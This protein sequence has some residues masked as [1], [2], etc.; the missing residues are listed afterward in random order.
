VIGIPNRHPADTF[1]NRQLDGPGH[2]QGR[3]IHSRGEVPVP[4]FQVAQAT[5]HPGFG[6]NPNQPFLYAPNESRE[7]V[8]A[9]GIHAI[10]AILGEYARAMG[11]FGPGKSKTLQHPEEFFFQLIE[12]DSHVK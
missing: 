1:R 3:G 12:G 4:A 9:V 8:E 5:H 2:G 11:S 7:A 6:I 10:E